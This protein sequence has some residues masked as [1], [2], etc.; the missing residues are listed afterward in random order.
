MM[1]LK[2]I[3]IAAFLLFCVT[4]SYADGYPR[5]Y[6]IDMIHYAFNLTFSDQTDEMKG[7]A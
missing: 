4:H 1:K 2:S 7:I 6:A 5:N 3:I